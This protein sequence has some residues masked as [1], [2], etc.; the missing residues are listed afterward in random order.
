[1]QPEDLVKYRN[2]VIGADTEG[3]GL[4]IHDKATCLA[5]SFDDGED[6]FLA[7][8]QEGGGNN[9]DTKLVSKIL[10]QLVKQGCTIVF[11]NAQH[12]IRQLHNA[13]IDFPVHAV[14][15]TQILAPLLN[16]NSRFGLDNLAKLYLGE[17]KLDDKDLNQWCA[18]HFGGRATFKQQVG[19]YW[20]VPAPMIRKYCCSDAWLAF[21]LYKKLRPMIDDEGLSAIY[22]VERRLVPILVEMHR[23]GV[24]TDVD[25]AYE[26]RKRLRKSL[27]ENRRAW[28]EIAGDTNYRSGKQ[29]AVLFDELGIPYATNQETGNPIMRAAFLKQVQHKAASIITETRALEKLLDTFVTGYVINNTGEDGVI[30]GEFHQLKSESYGTVSGRFSSG[31]QLNLQ[32]LPSRDGIY[33]PLIRSLFVPFDGFRWV[34]IDYSQIEYR[35]L[36]HYAVETGGRLQQHY[37]EDPEIDFHDIAS[38]LLGLVARFGR[39]EGRK[40]GKNLNF[41]IVYGMGRAKLA[42]SL[43]I[44]ESEAFA[45]LDE[46]HARYPEIRKLSALA[47]RRAGARRMITTWG[48]R[49]RRFPRFRDKKG[50]SFD[51]TN[52]ALNA[53]LQ[54]SAADLM[55]MAMIRVAEIIDG[56]EDAYLHLTVHDELDLSIAPGARGDRI[57]R[58]IKR[59]MEDFCGESCQKQFGVKIPI[60]VPIIAEV[61]IGAN[62]GKQSKMNPNGL[63]KLANVA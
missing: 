16:E 6:F 36:A 52:T 59:A 7:W 5:L 57:I 26:V 39:K 61:E 14:E 29:L 19:N 38:E 44:D 55:K 28:Q 41:G 10:R 12:D 20:R 3:T 54:G 31:G 33:G 47:Q 37:I 23:T 62:W 43:G 18:D 45:M 42:R 11:H 30:H 21:K 2:C 27:N 35:F 22:N 63:V 17:S 1:M 25:R 13:G 40:I 60:S 34:K 48:G 56:S 58:E 46:Y 49:K 15:D 4:G 32:N 53:L 50:R 9:C 24:P 8:G 51:Q